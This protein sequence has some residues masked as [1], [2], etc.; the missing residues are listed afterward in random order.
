MILTLVPTLY[1]NI[2]A[3]FFI[4][5]APHD[6]SNCE[7]RCRH[8]KIEIGTLQSYKSV[9]MIPPYQI[10]ALHVTPTNHCTYHPYSFNI[11]YPG[12]PRGDGANLKGGGVNS[13]LG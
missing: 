6:V 7:I 1:S 12:F 10:P 13:Y 3:A 11:I 9:K 5:F 4:L 2:F 8:S